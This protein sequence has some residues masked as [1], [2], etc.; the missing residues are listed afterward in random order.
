MSTARVAA[1]A[2]RPAA[3]LSSFCGLLAGFGTF[4]PG[5]ALVAALASGS[6]VEAQ[7]AA[8]AR[9]LTIDGAIGPGTSDYV[10]RGLAAAADDEVAL[11]VLELDTPGGLDTSMR[12]IVRAI[13]ASPVP[14]VGYVTPRGARA[15][16]AGTYILYATHVAAMAP[17]TNLGAATPIAIGGAPARDPAADDGEATP[18]DE[19]ALPADAAARKAVND[20]VAYIRGLA[21][22]RGRNADWAERAVR[23]GES[24]SAEAALDLGVIEIIAA[25]HRELLEQIDGRTIVVDDVERTL[26]TAG[27]E[28]DRRDPDW[29]TRFLTV[30]GNPT[31]AYLLMLIGIYGLALEGYSPGALVP[32]T[33]GAISLLLALFAFQILPVNYAGLALVFLGVALMASEL[34]VPSFGVLGIGG[35]VAFAFGSIILIDSDIPGFEVS[36]PLIGAVSVAA[37]AGLLGILFLVARSRRAPV[38]S[39]VEQMV[40]S[41]AVAIDAFER[42]G[43]VLF[44]G[45]YW[46]AR[47]PTPVRSGEELV[48]TGVRG[49]VLD[50]QPRTYRQ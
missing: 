21:E 47:S 33:V 32:G 3:V 17:A 7:P 42:E 1:A 14:V 22:E 23:R 6:S 27:L 43:L 37:G 45:E 30:V 35:L 16:S 20:A 46:N 24:A 5:L 2:A 19:D 12:E 39:G 40:G 36:R 50:V 49:L 38:V 15:A 41:P 18:A 44:A 13:L 11:V 10:V 4:L 8:N 29:R 25:N 9:V 28:L 26:E 48:V 34:F 31:V